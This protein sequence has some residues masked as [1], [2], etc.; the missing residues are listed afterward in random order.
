M[1]YIN[2]LMSKSR[3]Y[4]KLS[5]K[6]K[7]AINILTTPGKFDEVT[8]E[9]EN[10]DVKER[11]NNLEIDIFGFRI[12]LRFKH[13]FNEGV[14]QY[15]VINDDAHNDSIEILYGLRF[16]HLGNFKNEEYTTWHIPDFKSTNAMILN[17]LLDD[18]AKKQSC[19]C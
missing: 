10:Y 13:T 16:D 12:Y 4:E 9:L 3:R 1:R 15:F 2:E 19:R 18:L 5:N 11:N 17:E 6:L 7:E 14:I 8:G